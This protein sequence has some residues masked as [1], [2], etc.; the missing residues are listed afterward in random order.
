[1]ESIWLFFV[2][3]ENWICSLHRCINNYDC[4]HDHRLLKKKSLSRIRIKELGNA[5][6]VLETIVCLSYKIINKGFPQ[7]LVKIYSKTHFHITSLEYI[8]T[9]MMMMMMMMMMIMNYFVKRLTDRRR[10]MFSLPQISGTWGAV[11][12]RVLNL[13]PD[14]DEWRCL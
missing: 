1:M 11:S 3:S 5:S 10:Q 12:E 7:Y 8:I 13:S 4:N 6:L 2:Y 14:F 9:M